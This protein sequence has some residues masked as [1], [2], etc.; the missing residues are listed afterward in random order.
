TDRVTLTTPAGLVVGVRAVMPGE[1][2]WD[3]EEPPA[4]STRVILPGG[5]EVFATAEHACAGHPRHWDW[6]WAVLPSGN[7]VDVEAAPF[8]GEAKV[9][10]RKGGGA[11]EL[12]LYREAPVRGGTRVTPGRWDGYV[13]RPASGDQEPLE[14]RS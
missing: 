5:T 2:A 13:L 8:Q 3:P 11:E 1:A 12:P 10:V 14:D 6:A 4:D 9:V 7:E